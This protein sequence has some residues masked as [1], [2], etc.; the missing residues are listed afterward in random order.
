MSGDSDTDA[1]R[2]LVLIRFIN[3]LDKFE[4]NSSTKECL[5]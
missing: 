1:H 3:A 4:I 2:N 5:K